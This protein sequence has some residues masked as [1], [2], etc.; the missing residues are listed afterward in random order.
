MRWVRVS[1]F[2]VVMLLLIGSVQAALAHA[3]YVSSEP[4]QGANVALAPSNVTVTFTEDLDPASTTLK[5]VGPDGQDVTNGKTEVSTSATKVATVP[6]K[7]GG[8]GTYTV[9]WHSVSDD[10]KHAEDGSFTFTVGA[11]GQVAPAT[12]HTQPGIGMFQG[13]LELVI[14][15]GGLLL[16][17]L[18]GALRLRR[19]RQ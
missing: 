17:M 1:P 13:S 11:A 14:G 4:G 15:V 16:L 3:E 5:V 9:N 18:G 2:V 19:A 6:I 8:D 7:A 10:D 12:G